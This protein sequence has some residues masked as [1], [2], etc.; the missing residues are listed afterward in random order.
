MR[1]RQRLEQERVDH[2]E[3]GGVRADPERERQDGDDGEAGMLDELAKAV[4]DVGHHNLPNEWLFDAQGD[5]GI[6][7]GGAARR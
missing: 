5:D 1:E 2:A 4:T 6:N 3:D 7:F